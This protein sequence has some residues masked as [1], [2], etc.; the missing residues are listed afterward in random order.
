MKAVRGL[1]PLL[2]LTA[3]LVACSA[4]P[5]TVTHEPQSV[6][7]VAADSCSPLLQELAL[8][9]HEA[10]PWVTV[11]VETFDA[12]VAGERVRDG[13]FDLAALTWW[14]ETASGWTQPFARDAVVIIVNPAV[15]VTEMGLVELREI[16]SGRSGE[17]SDGTPVQ[18]VSREAGS[19]LRALLDERVMDGHDVT[20]TALVVPDN[21]SMLRVVAETPGAIGYVALGRLE[22]GVRPLAIEGVPPQVDTLGDNW[23]AYHLLF[24]APVEPQGAALDFVQWVLGAQGQQIVTQALGPAP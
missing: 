9:Y 8:A 24:A 6:R 13:A 18:V 1:L 20:L 11:E 16:L 17:W 19:G 12:A 5:L 22:R 23:L 10:H 15:P 2:L 7:I 3:F 4:P 14:D 21:E